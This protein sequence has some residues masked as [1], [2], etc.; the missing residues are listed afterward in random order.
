MCLADCAWKRLQPALRL[1]LQRVLSPESLVPV[2]R[3]NPDEDWRMLRDERL[4]YL[5]PVDP[6]D[7][8][9]ERHHGVFDCPELKVSQSFALQGLYLGHTLA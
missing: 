8:L 6:M 3:S 1:P 4:R 7:R 5:P 9:R 2:A